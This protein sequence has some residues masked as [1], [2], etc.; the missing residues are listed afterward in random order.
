MTKNLSLYILT[1]LHKLICTA[2]TAIQRLAYFNGIHSYSL[3]KLIAHL[4]A[5]YWPILGYVSSV[6][7]G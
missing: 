5:A 7:V 4:H 3:C 6:C 1:S 2:C